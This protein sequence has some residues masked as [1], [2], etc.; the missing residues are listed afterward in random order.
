MISKQEF[1]VRFLSLLC[2]IASGLMNCP[3]ITGPWTNVRGAGAFISD[4]EFY[5]DSLE[6]LC[7]IATSGGTGGLWGGITVAAGPPPID[8][9]I[10]TLFYKDSVSNFI[11]INSGTV[12]NPTWDPIG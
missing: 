6:L 2:Q 3:S 4:Q 10:T 8:G 1:Y 7:Q 11:W 9:T 5:A 12:A